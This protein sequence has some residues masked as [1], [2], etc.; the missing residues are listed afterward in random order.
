MSI[1]GPKKKENK[2]MNLTLTDSKKIVKLATLFANLKTLS[3]NVVLHFKTEGLYIQS[4][5]DSH[6]SLL[7]CNLLST[8][9]NAYTVLEETCRV[10]IGLQMFHKVLQSR[11]E[12]QSLMLSLDAASDVIVV[13]FES[14]DPARTSF[15]K[16]FELPLMNIE[17]DLVE[18]K[19]HT[20]V[21]LELDS[22]LFTDLIHQLNMF[23]DSLTLVFQE[24]VIDLISSGLEGSMKAVI[25]IQDVKSYVIPE[26]PVLKQSYS[27]KYLQLMCQFN[28]LSSE[29]ILGFGEHMPM[30]MRYNVSDDGD[31]YVRIH[32]APKINPDAEDGPADDGPADAEPADDGDDEY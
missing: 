2:K 29:M 14:S 8:W 32:L 3:S 6:C 17:M 11:Q 31:N 21:D 13:A 28:K 1:H 24:D 12:N 23:D 27:L 25:K 7:E 20:E 30:S 18:I 15:D 22:K 4:M 9:F 10:G 26:G 19:E 16:R 5:D